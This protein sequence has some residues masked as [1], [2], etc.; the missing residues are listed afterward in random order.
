MILGLKAWEK[1]SKQSNPRSE[2]RIAATSPLAVDFANFAMVA[3]TF[4]GR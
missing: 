1:Q 4:N 2:A 3:G